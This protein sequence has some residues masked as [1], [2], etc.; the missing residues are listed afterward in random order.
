MTQQSPLVT[1]P[2]SGAADSTVFFEL[3]EVPVYCNVLW[4]T[5]AQA[6]AAAR[7]AIR[8]A[9]S[10]TSG[11]IFNAAFDPALMDYDQAY[12]N[13][14]HFSARFRQ[15]A[16]EL[17]TRLTNTYDLHGK[18]VI[19][20]GCGKGDFLKLLVQ[21]G[22]NRGWGF[23]RSYVPQS[24]D[25][26]YNITFVQDFYTEQYRS[27]PA[28]F[29]TCRH[30]LEHIETPQQFL[31]GIRRAIAGRRDVVVYFEVPN[32]LYTL[33]DLGIWDI[34]YEHCGYYSPASLAHLFASGGF[35]ILDVR[36]VY[37][38][39]F[40][41]IEA[42]LNADAGSAAANAFGSP[43]AVQQLVD[44]FAENYRR[45]VGEWREQL[46]S[47][48]GKRIV[49]WGGGSKGVTFLNIMQTSDSIEFMVDINPRKQGMYVA[50]TGQ[51]IVAP[52][53]L[54]QY[55]PAV[56]IIMNPVYRDEIRSMTDALGIYPD[57]MLV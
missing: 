7:A 35:D 47:M 53:F 19:D 33:R 10:L 18:A 40:L 34:I 1:D 32:V 23:D 57:F 39:Q 28:D 31:A 29:I 5:Q 26:Q 55:N 15:F 30:V 49:T 12:E 45:K 50:G 42:K 16:E 38:G 24:D 9:F 25:A 54:K 48:Q 41:S 43:A 44:T 52:D 37:G 13:S 27:T 21:T 3:P 6:F 51:Q 2:V 20:V 46:A 11:H 22:N 4:E 14:L 8:L 17:V 56:V 36:E